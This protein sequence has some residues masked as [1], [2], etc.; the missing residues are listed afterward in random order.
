M[1]RLWEQERPRSY[2][3]TV[4]DTERGERRLSGYLT[5]ETHLLG[6]ELPRQGIG[7]S[8]QWSLSKH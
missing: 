5:R 4:G 1:E 7:D 3:E 6:E 8:T 2:R